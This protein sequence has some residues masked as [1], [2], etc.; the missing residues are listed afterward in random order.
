MCFIISLNCTS[1]PH[2]H[3]FIFGN[4][5]LNFLVELRG[6]GGGGGGGGGDG[7]DDGG[8]GGDGSKCYSE[9]WFKTLKSSS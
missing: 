4:A 8:G 5:L 9:E 3:I 1:L 7:G 2:K 6:G